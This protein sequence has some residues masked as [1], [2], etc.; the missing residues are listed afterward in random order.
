MTYNVTKSLKGWEGEDHVMQMTMSDH[1]YSICQDV[2]EKFA[3]PELQNSK[4][5]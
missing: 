4:P 5:W 1:E 2:A 3:F